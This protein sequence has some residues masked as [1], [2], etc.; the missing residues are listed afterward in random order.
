[1]AKNTAST[2]KSHV[3]YAS[4]AKVKRSYKRRPAAKNVFHARYDA[5]QTTTDNSKHWANADGVGPDASTAP[6]IRAILR[7]RSRYECENNSYAKGIVRTVA[8]DCIGTGPR[9]QMLLPNKNQNAKIERFFSVWS[10]HIDLAR[11]LRRMRMARLVDGEIFAIMSD[12]LKLK[13]EVKLDLRLIEADRITTPYGM[14]TGYDPNEVD[15][16]VYDEF[17]NPVSYTIYS[18][19]SGDYSL[20]TQFDRVPAEI[21]IHWGNIERSG[22]HRGI[23]EITPALPLFAQLRRYTLA[24]LAAAE[25]AADFAAVFYTDLPNN[26]PEDMNSPAFDI[27]ELEKRMGMFLPAGWKLD[28]IKAEQPTTTYSEFKKEIL[29]E[30]ARC[31]NIPFNVAAGNSSGYNYASGRL[32]HQVYFKSIKVDRRDTEN[33]ILY[34]ILLAFLSEAMLYSDFSFLRRYITAAASLDEIPHQWFWDGQEHVDPGKEASAQQTRLLSNTTTLAAEY[35][36]QGKDYEVELRQRA[37]E[38][39]LMKE[40]GIESPA[41]KIGSPVNKKKADDEDEDEKDEENGEE[42]ENQ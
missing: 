41:K 10:H 7:N 21:V 32:D 37:S 5:A 12:N 28:Q 29:N 31:L 19:K 33:Q 23:P 1:M 26:M 39:K 25:T 17:D 30:I 34:P 6:S 13:T 36:A 9:L 35:A 22:Q 2:L 20:P 40:L 8:N 11:K 4:P 24:V 42:D 16:I 3:T 27:V 15:G 14:N 18:Y 38:I